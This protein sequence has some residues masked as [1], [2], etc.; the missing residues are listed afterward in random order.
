MKFRVLCL[1]L[2]GLFIVQPGLATAG[3][4][5]KTG[6]AFEDFGDIFQIALPAGA[7]I[8]TLFAGNGEGGM[9]DKQGSKQFVYSFGTA[10][11]TTYLL[12]ASVQKMRPGEGARSSFP[13]GHTMGAFSGA[14]FLGARYGWKYGLPA[15]TLAALTGASRVY[16]TWH[17]ADDVVAGASISMLSTW[18][19]TTPHSSLF[20][21]MPTYDE[22][23][24]GIT[25]KL[26]GP[27]RDRAVD[28]DQPAYLP[29]IDRS[30]R[31][32][33]AFGP[34]LLIRNEIQSP[35]GGTRFDLSDFEKRDDPT[36]TA[37]AMFDWFV[38]ERWTLRLFYSPFESQDNGTFS[39]PVDFAGQTFPA[40]TNINSA[41]R[42]HDIR[43]RASYHWLRGN[44]FNLNLGL[45]LI[46]Q[47]HYIRL[48]SPDVASRVEDLVILPFGHLKMSYTL[49]KSWSLAGEL[50]WMDY[51]DDSMFNGA[52][53][54]QWQIDPRWEMIAGY[55]FYNRDV[56]TEKLANNVSYDL[57]MVGFGHSWK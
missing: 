53:F 32:S 33:F 4:D 40:D 7:A 25:V 39:E 51:K 28:P 57:L 41:W 27:G 8:S 2:L 16:S 17:Y 13:S 52:I 37:L 29:M 56:R 54:A 49:Y 11:S 47:H 55:Q 30:A 24:V 46:G 43:A 42:L 15:Y 9:W 38:S 31:Y 35:S 36:T 44:R 34:A 19:Y 18:L 5:S 20:Q 12:K 10:W 48:E 50:G 23:G 3:G 45:G 14:S 22:N 21:A 6:T 1:V 26:N